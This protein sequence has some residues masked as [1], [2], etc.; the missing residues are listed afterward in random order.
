MLS[1]DLCC[2][3]DEDSANYAK[4]WNWYIDGDNSCDSDMS[5][6]EYRHPYAQKYYKDKARVSYWTQMFQKA[7]D[8]TE[9]WPWILVAGL[10]LLFLL[11]IV[12]V[13]T[14]A[15]VAGVG[16]A[17]WVGGRVRRQ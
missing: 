6:G 11:F 17:A 7:D 12:F 14:L 1:G 15:V 3:V 5:E 2:T 10:N 8:V 9:D 4:S 13:I 16:F